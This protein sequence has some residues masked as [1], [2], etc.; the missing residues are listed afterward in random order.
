M[1]AAIGKATALELELVRCM[2]ERNQ[3]ASWDKWL[4]VVSLR[5][6]ELA[7]KKVNV[8]YDW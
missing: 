5:A 6:M 1:R 8:Q 7:H 2:N 3:P 4:F